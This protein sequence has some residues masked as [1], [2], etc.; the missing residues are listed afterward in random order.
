MARY[1]AVRDARVLALYDF[2]TGLA[3]L[4][5]PPPDLQ[6]LLGAVHGNQAAMAAFASVGAG[7]LAPAELVAPDHG[8]GNLAAGNLAAARELPVAAAS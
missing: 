6:Q 7:S 4:Q 2:A 5:P 3:T 1:R 8:A